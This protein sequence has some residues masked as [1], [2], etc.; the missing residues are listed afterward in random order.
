MPNAGSLSRVL[1]SPDESRDAPTGRAARSTES[2]GREKKLWNS[3]LNAVSRAKIA[4]SSADPAT[5]AKRDPAAVAS[6]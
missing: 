3:V 2:A 6:P 1:R 4:D 5:G